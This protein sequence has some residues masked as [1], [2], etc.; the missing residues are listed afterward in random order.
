MLHIERLTRLC[1]LF[2]LSS[3]VQMPYDAN[4]SQVVGII[5]DSK[6]NQCADF[7]LIQQDAVNYLINDKFKSNFIELQLVNIKY[8]FEN[9]FEYHNSIIDSGP[10]YNEDNQDLRIDEF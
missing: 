10:Q 2:D 9:F 1:R 7:Q 3:L 6:K 4:Y 5:S 8:T